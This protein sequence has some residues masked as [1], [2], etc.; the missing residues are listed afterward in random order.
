[1]DAERLAA[2]LA[3]EL[4]ADETAAVEAALAR[5]PAVRSSL[6][7]LERADAALASLPATQLPAGFERRLRAAID[8]ELATQLRPAADP[9][10]ADTRTTAHPHGEPARDELA[11]RRARRTPR[12]MPALAGAA[13]AVAVVAGAVVGVGVLGGGGDEAVTDSLMTLEADD[14]DGAEAADVLPGPGDLPTLV[15]GDRELDDDLADELLASAELQAVAQRGLAPAEGRSLGDSWRRAFAGFTAVQSQAE[16]GVG[17]DAAADRP[18]AAEDTAEEEAASDDLT[19][20]ERSGG[21]RVLADGPLSEADNEAV[22]RCLTEVLSGGD[23][24]PAY[25]ELATYDGEPAVVIG[26]VT[27]DPASGTYSRPEVWIL[28]R[29]DCQVRRF[30]QG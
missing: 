25:L 22:D 8:E 13:A 27:F 28:D 4:D 5:D 26:L 24:I 2:Y 10:A 12:W 30:S 9:A 7:A 18:D 17:D 1:V 6:E 23:A 3:G 21:V 29:Q 11:S 20:L 15:V 14:A 19:A 16:A